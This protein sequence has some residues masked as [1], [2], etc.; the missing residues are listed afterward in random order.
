M[1]H[2]EIPTSMADPSVIHNGL[3][4]SPW[5]TDGAY[6]LSFAGPIAVDPGPISPTSIQSEPCLQS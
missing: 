3:D 4:P 5:I 6:T 1:V 2:Q